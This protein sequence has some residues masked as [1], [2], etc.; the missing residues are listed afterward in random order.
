M[1]KIPDIVRIGTCSWKYPSWK[2]IIYPEGVSDNYL[3]EYAK[4]YDTVEIDQWFWSLFPGNKVVL[5]KSEVVRE[6]VSSVPKNFRFSVKVPNSIT[7]THHYSQDKNIPLIEN[8]F[9]LSN[10]LFAD[11]YHLLEPMKDHLA[12]LIFQFEYLNKKKM[13][14]QQVFQEKFSKFISKCPSGMNYCVE[15]RNPNYLNKE[16][17]TFLKS[18]NLSHV[19]L[20]GYYMPPIFTL[21]EKYRDFIEK[22]AVIR[23][24]G[25]NRKTIEEK[26]Q[27]NW[28]QLWEPKDEELD[29]LAVM[30]RDMIFKKI[31]LFI[32]VNNHYEGSAPLTI[33]RIVSLL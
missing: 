24:M 7:L 9:F 23:L 3:S 12:T 2:G 11:F 19:F 17:F 10:E 25:G 8:S 30:M 20:Q 26:S 4:H 15:I 31:V 14:D 28:S 27:G 5:P 6:Y 18:S 16:Y 33:K 1:K 13:S 22:F 29:H 21:Y 32:N